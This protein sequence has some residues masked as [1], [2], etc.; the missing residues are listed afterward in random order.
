MSKF[1]ILALD[2][3]GL[4]GLLTAIV[5]KRLCK[6]PDLGYLFDSVDLIAGTFSASIRH[7]AG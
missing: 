2:G 4:R 3:G 6:E 7:E 1:R 5:L